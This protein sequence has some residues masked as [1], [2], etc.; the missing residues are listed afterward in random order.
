[1]ISCASF[2]AKHS[3]RSLVLVALASCLLQ[4]CV[5]YKNY[6][7]VPVIRPSEINTNGYTKVYVETLTDFDRYHHDGELIRSAVIEQLANGKQ[8][9][10]LMQP[11]YKAVLDTGLMIISG[12]VL[13]Y[14]YREDIKTEEKCLPRKIWYKDSTGKKQEKVVNDSV[15]ID[16]TRLGALDI[17]VQFRISDAATGTLLGVRTL[18]DGVSLRTDQRNGTPAPIRLAPAE[19]D[20][21]MRIASALAHLIFPYKVYESVVLFWDEELPELRRGNSFASSGEWDY[22]IAEYKKAISA[23]PKHQNIH[24]AW[25]DMG[26]AYQ[27]TLNF[28]KAEE[29]FREALRLEPDEREYSN[30]ISYCRNMEANQ[31]ELTK[32]RK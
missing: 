31:H 3:L 11:A 27:Y 4:S 12:S 22:A 9:Q 5:N 30:A 19:T 26:I 20:V 6:I 32:V 1:M 21:R 2:F 13:N 24:K 23:N 18:S 29:C 25:Y 17:S 14:S 15:V 16:Y 8:V 7:S 28:A 10:V